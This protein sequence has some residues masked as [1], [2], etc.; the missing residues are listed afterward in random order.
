MQQAD[1]AP[2]TE[3]LD[4]VCSLLSRGAYK[5]N[6]MNTALFFR[7]LGRYSLDDVRAG[8]DAHVADPARGKF[9][10]VPA[11]ILHQI[12]ERAANDGRLGP[13]EAW[14]L[15]TLAADES[16]TVVWTDEIARAYST[17][18]PVLRAG[19]KVG[20]RRTFLESYERLVA[21]ARAGRF[22]TQWILSEGS[23]VEL[24]ARAIA[25]GV[26]AG[27]LARADFPALPAPRGQVPL[28]C[29]PE[30]VGAARER[31]VA[32][33]GVLREFL[34]STEPAVS[35]DGLA[36]VDT[37]RRKAE[38]QALVDARGEAGDA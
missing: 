32:A 34:T 22:P 1:L 13:D 4:A 2:F 11:D 24:R 17:A 35:A 25:D 37:A 26:T 30:E 23:D 3:M 19:D 7:A 9:V 8:F 12:A 6:A 36:K 28:L 14:S 31:A 16:Q 20:A 18:L 10:P 38:A 27:R 21:A 33:L 29:A 5:P 15:A